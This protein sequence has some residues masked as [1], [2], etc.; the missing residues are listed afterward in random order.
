MHISKYPI[1]KIKY[2]LTYVESIVYWITDAIFNNNI[3]RS[4][5]QSHFVKLISFGYTS[6]TLHMSFTE[7]NDLRDFSVRN[8]SVCISKLFYT[9]RNLVNP[10][11]ILIVITI[12]QYIQYQ[13]EFRLVLNLS[14]KGKYISNLVLIKKIQRIFPCVQLI[15]PITQTFTR[16]IP[17]QFT[18]V[19]K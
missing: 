4:N 2:L 6:H 15:V 7:S 1:I 10:N 16:V 3:T 11:Q 14:V 5:I 9:Q 13:S 8:H 18:A 19:E 17:P 12:F